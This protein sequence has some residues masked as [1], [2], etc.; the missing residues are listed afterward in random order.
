MMV[1]YICS[2]L[3]CMVVYS[4]G[5]GGGNTQCTLLLTVREGRQL[6]S[7]IGDREATGHPGERV[8]GGRGEGG[9]GTYRVL[10]RG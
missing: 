9:E 7:R 3:L 1:I 5:V 8:I 4:G 6:H 2:P 10:E